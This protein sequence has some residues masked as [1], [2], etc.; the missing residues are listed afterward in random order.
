MDLNTSLRRVRSGVA[1]P[2]LPSEIKAWADLTGNQLWAQEYNILREMDRK[3][4]EVIN[5]ELSDYRE[6][7]AEKAKNPKR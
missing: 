5:N 4:C 6:R 1:E 7:E 3:Y 2:M